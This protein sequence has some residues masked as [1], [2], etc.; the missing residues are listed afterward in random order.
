M[1]WL[2][3]FKWLPGGDRNIGATFRDPKARKLDALI[4]S[5]VQRNNLSANDFEEVMIWWVAKVC[6]YRD[7]YIE[8]FCELLRFHVLQ[9]RI[10][11]Q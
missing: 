3:D 4:R 10:N 8:R 5:F 1:N 7:D 11:R 9:R 2:P 6:G